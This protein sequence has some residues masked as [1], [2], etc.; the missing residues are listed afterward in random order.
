VFGFTLALPP[1]IVFHPSFAVWFKN[2]ASKFISPAD[3]STCL[4]QDSGSHCVE[5]SSHTQV[6]ISARSTLYLEGPGISAGALVLDG[7]LIVKARPGRDS[8]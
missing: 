8:W 5:S 7:T 4:G 2:F 3:V 6:R 1:R